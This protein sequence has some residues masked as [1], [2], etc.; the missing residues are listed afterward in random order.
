[1]LCTEE[2]RAYE[3]SHMC[4]KQRKAFYKALF[5][6]AWTVLLLVTL[7]EYYAFCLLNVLFI[8]FSSPLMSCWLTRFSERCVHLHKRCCRGCIVLSGNDLP[9]RSSHMAMNRTL[10]LFDSMCSSIFHSGS[11]RLVL[12]IHQSIP[13]IYG[14]QIKPQQFCMSFITHCSWDGTSNW[15]EARLAVSLSTLHFSGHSFFFFCPLEQKVDG[16]L[17]SYWSSRVP[18]LPTEKVSA[19]AVWDTVWFNSLKN[20]FFFSVRSFS[21]SQTVFVMLYSILFLDLIVYAE[22]WWHC[23]NKTISCSACILTRSSCGSS[24]YFNYSEGSNWFSLKWI[25]RLLVEW[26]CQCEFG[27]V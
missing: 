17:D 10:V 4:S 25:K 16:T 15:G 27:P 3:R 18:P 7:I 24:R 9:K 13:H 11:Y 6:L 22:I 5:P 1:M 8:S 12:P 20:S 19:T 23:F 26:W 2:I 14:C 21:S